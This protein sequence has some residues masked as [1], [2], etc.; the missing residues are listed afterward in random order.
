MI[1]GV[2]IGGTAVKLGLVDHN[3]VICARREASVC[4]D[5]YR[6]PILDTVLKEA[7]TFVR[8]S[9]ETIEG[10]GVSAAGQIDVHTGVVIG[11]NGHI[12]HYEGS[13][14]KEK[15][16]ALFGV[17]AWVIN[18]ANA[19]VLGECVAGGASGCRNVLMFTLG[20]GVG[21]GVVMDGHILGGALGI[22][23]EMGH[24]T[25]YQDGIEC[26]CGKRGC[27]ECY[28]STS[29]L[30]RAAQE[31]TGEKLNGRIIFERVA[32]GDGVLQQVVDHWIDDIA[33]GITGMVHVFNPELVLIGG[34]VS[35]Q[36]ELL[37]KPL[38]RKVLAGV[39]P[40][41]GE[42]LRVERATL[43]NDAGLIGA[44]QFWREHQ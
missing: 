11:T 10:V 2:D 27:Y 35:A 15:M 28:A 12:P 3:G 19:A 6:T 4:F 36:E 42:G 9:G 21:G 17:P 5:E 18:D 8:E 39:M 29:A 23:G 43:G 37:M 26:S 14:I 30:V 41:F 20:T 38:R 40:R 7:E 34:G 13:P 44:V 16:E 22:G 24:M 32:Q 31:A 25:L 1:L 33:G